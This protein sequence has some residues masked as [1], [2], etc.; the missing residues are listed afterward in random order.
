MISNENIILEQELLG[1]LINDN[2]LIYICRDN[3]KFSMFQLEAHKQIY[4]TIDKMIKENITVDALNLIKY[5]NL[6]TN[7]LGGMH[8]IMEV[9]NCSV[10]NV[11]YESKIKFF[12]DEFR[13]R[14]L[15]EMVKELPRSNNIDEMLDIIN[16][17][18]GVVHKS[19]V[20]KDIDLCSS[21]EEYLNNLYSDVEEIGFKSGLD[22]L[23]D[24]LGNLQRGR[25]ITIFAR[26]GIGKSTFAIQMA[27][28]LALS[29]IKVIYGSGEMSVIEVLNKMVS[30]K[31]DIDYKKLNKKILNKNEKD[32]VAQFTTVLLSSKLHIS[33]ETDINK[34]FSEI[35]LYKLKHGLDVVFVDYINKYINT[36]KGNNLTEK[37]GDITSQLKNLAL[38]EDICIVMLAQANRR[39]D[40]NGME[41]IT[42]KLNSSDIQDSARI[43]QDSDQIVALYR[44]LKL[45]NR[46]TRDKAFKDGLLDIN[47]RRSDKNPYCINATIIKNRHGEKTTLAFKWDGSKSRI[48]NWN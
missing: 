35:K 4:I 31:L 3:I 27:L 33:N 37:L 8:Y 14:E 6:N 18:L 26:S 34:F 9:S 16:I 41:P 24:S 23:D 15:L 17:H 1:G 12:V 39:V 38:K 47:S 42:D 45:D 44:N 19:N 43:E 48:S 22:V 13:K 36:A 20:I 21:Y 5:S 30:S 29:K 25:L 28:N 40:S 7:K 32:K 2:S 46:M 11:N 10:S